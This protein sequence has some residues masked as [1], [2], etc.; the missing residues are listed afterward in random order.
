M[1]DDE[2]SMETIGIPTKIAVDHCKRAANLDVGAQI[3][4]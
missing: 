3:T 4:A 1:F 2:D